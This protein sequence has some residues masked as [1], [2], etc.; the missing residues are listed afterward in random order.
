MSNAL[1]IFI[2]ESG[3]F[4]F[5]PTGTKYFALTAVS[6]VKPLNERVKFSELR[7]DLL[8]QSVDQEFFHAT[9][10]AQLTRDKVFDLIENTINDIS[11]DSVIAQKNKAHWSLYSVQT[12]DQN[13]KIKFVK[14][15]NEFYR[16]LA[17]TCF[18]TSS[19]VTKILNWT[20]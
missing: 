9:E 14:Q 6:T 17:K 15:E 16:L 1:Y 4:D 13:W 19:L 2:D 3:N 5:S 11:V 12:P 10:D 20:E 18:D 8:T 7:Y